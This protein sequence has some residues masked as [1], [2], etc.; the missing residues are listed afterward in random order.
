MNP[1]KQLEDLDRNGAATPSR[2]GRAVGKEAKPLS[3]TLTHEGKACRPPPQTPPPWEGRRFPL[4]FPNPTR[5]LVTILAALNPILLAVV[6]ITLAGLARS[7]ACK[8]QVL[9][10][11][12][13]CSVALT[14]DR[15]GGKRSFAASAFL[16]NAPFKADVRF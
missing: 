3:Q 15:Q 2:G 4:P 13:R 10:I 9:D 11:R 5:S 14:Q 1:Q 6:S 7:N 12:D 16:N 8:L